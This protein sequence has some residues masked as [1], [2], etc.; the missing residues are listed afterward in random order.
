[1]YFIG[2]SVAGPFPVYAP[3][4][5]SED[6]GPHLRRYAARPA[7]PEAGCHAALTSI[8]KVLP[9]Y[10]MAT[11]API[12]HHLSLYRYW[13]SK[14]GSRLM[15]AR[16][17]LSPGDIPALLPFLVIVGK[18]GNQLRYRLMGTAVVHAIGYD[19]TGKAV[20]AYIV[21]R[22]DGV[23]MRA[24]YERVFTGAR[25]VF[26]TGE[27]IFRSGAHLN[28]SLLT[29]PLSDD[30]AAVNMT[31]S[32]LATRTNTSLVAERGWLKGLPITIC[33]V[34]DVGSAEE[35]ETLCREWEQCSAPLIR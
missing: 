19:A 17:D 9:L 30:G 3:R 12:S 8:N 21:S 6:R 25:P 4:F 7:C 28:M 32:S 24:I 27:F 11:G 16:R 5:S 15:P 1:L 18:T 22:P 26:S 10:G 2:F 29:L 20:G 23:E 14:R 35:L 13:L 34:L 33:D 31:V